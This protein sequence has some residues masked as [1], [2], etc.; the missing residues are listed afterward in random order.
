[1][2]TDCKKGENMVS[3]L[4][5]LGT[6]VYLKEGKIKLMIVSHQPVLKNDEGE[7]YYDY[8]AISQII[9]LEPNRVVYF[10]QENFSKVFF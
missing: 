5:P 1:M 9:G 8:A 10:N 3:G 4:L 7:F 6:I 2:V